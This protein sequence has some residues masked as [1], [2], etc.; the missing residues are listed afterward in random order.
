M[1]SE[2]EEKRINSSCSRREEKSKN[3]CVTLHLYTLTRKHV[4]SLRFLVCT[5]RAWENRVGL[6]WFIAR[7]D[8]GLP[9]TQKHFFLLAIRSLKRIPHYPL[10]AKISLR[11]VRAAVV[12]L[13]TSFLFFRVFLAQFLLP[14]FPRRPR[15]RARHELWVRNFHFFPENERLQRAALCFIGTEERFLFQEFLWLYTHTARSFR[16]IFPRVQYS[17]RYSIL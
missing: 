11:P 10:S 14:F 8:Y 6:N 7:R 12:A 17:I 13:C 1:G 9:P 16:N 5:Q 3:I 2:A 15:T 4:K